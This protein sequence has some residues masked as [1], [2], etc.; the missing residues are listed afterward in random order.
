[1]DQR[2]RPKLLFVEDEFLI[3]LTVAEALSDDGFE[4]LEAASGEEALQLLGADPS[5]ALL[6]T[7]LQLPGKIDGG[8]LVR[9][10]RET[11]PDLPVILVTG[12][13]EQRASA[14]ASPRDMVIVKPYLPSEVSAAVR[15]MLG[16]PPA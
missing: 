5:V 11:R 10:A 15:R 4:V 8:E 16:L 6:L 14:A 1:M 2:H 12:R 3:R 13:P 9:R 7:D